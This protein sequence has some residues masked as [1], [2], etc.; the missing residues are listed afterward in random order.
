M[1]L[2]LSPEIRLQALGALRDYDDLVNVATACKGLKQ[3]L[4][5]NWKFVRP[6]G[7][8]VLDLFTKQLPTFFIGRQNEEMSK[9]PALPK[10]MCGD[11]ITQYFEI[12]SGNQSTLISH[13][14]TP[15]CVVTS[16]LVSSC[17]RLTVQ[18]GG[19][20]IWT[21]TAPT[22]SM[23]AA[24]NS[25]FDI[26][27]HLKFLPQ[28]GYHEQRLVT[29]SPVPIQ[30]QIVEQWYEQVENERLAFPVR[31]PEDK[32]LF[33]AAKQKTDHYYKLYYRN[34]VEYIL[35]STQGENLVDAFTFTFDNN[36]VVN[37]KAWATKQKQ[38][39]GNIFYKIPFNDIVNFGRVDRS[40]LTIHF[41]NK[42]SSDVKT[43]IVSVHS[44]I[45]SFGN[46]MGGLMFA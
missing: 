2:Q 7:Q 44:N 40:D 18:I 24:G 27:T 29:Q 1:L 10:V 28:T 34:I 43:H 12:Q 9:P 5:Q 6:N 8:Y 25:Y 38:Q 20:D 35:V 45:L 11:P 4:V 39:S 30:V 15:G 31:T 23:L 33:Y 3:L 46:G 41:L 42:S 13:F 37:L 21:C 26:M 16:L 22:F 32:S 14:H 17:D 19:A 36:V